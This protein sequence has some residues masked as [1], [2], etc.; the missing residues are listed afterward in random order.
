MSWE[1][2]NSDIDY[3]LNISAQLKKQTTLPYWWCEITAL[4]AS[5]SFSKLCSYPVN[6]SNTLTKTLNIQTKVLCDISRICFCSSSLNIARTYQLLTSCVFIRYPV[7]AWFNQEYIIIQSWFSKDYC[8]QAISLISMWYSSFTWYVYPQPSTLWSSGCW[9]Y[10]PSCK[11]YN[12]D[13]YI[14]ISN[15]IAFIVIELLPLQ[16]VLCEELI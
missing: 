5:L 12:Y 7:L 2:I 4:Q 9:T 10:K 14:H 1:V 6:N 8:L 16:Y 15:T 3:S 13:I 11:C